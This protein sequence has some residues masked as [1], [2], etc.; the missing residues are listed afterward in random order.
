YVKT[1]GSTGL[2][3]LLPLGGAL[4]YEQSRTLA[5]LLA[6]ITVAA[7]PQIATITRAVERRQ[8][9]VY[10]DYLQ[11][12][13]GRLIVAPYSVRPVPGAAVSMPL[14]WREVRSGLVSQRY[15]I[16]NALRRLRSQRADPWEGL[17]QQTPDLHAI[18]LRLGE[19]WQA[20]RPS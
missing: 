5:E 7:L 2:H 20:H 18:L 3:I 4:G 19:R 1:T 10:I 14:A 9:K 12:G 16:A 6:R 17:L 13:H 15:T 8:N 11:N